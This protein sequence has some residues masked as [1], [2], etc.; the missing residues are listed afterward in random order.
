MVGSALVL[1]VIAVLFLRNQIRPIRQLAEAAE[2]FG[3]GHD[4]PDFRP[5][6]AAE[7]RQAGR[8]FMVMRN[9]IQ[10]QVAT[11][12]E[13]LAGISHDLRTPLTRMKLQL[14]MMPEGEAAEALAYD[15]SV[16]EHMI[17][18][19]LDFA[20]GDIGETAEEEDMDQFIGRIAG[21][22]QNHDGEVTFKGASQT[23]MPVRR[24][25][26]ARALHNL[27]DNAL[28]YGGG[29]A[30]IATRRDGAYIVITIADAG[31]GVPEDKMEEI[32]QPFRR[33]E[34]SRNQETGGAGLGLSIARDA[35]QSHGG[36]IELRNRKKGG[37]LVTINL[38]VE[39]QSQP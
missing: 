9:R 11:R 12:T 37:L 36:T 28:R 19:Y 39:Q 1:L 6:G 22:Y 34:V 8:A 33:M 17:Q 18:E 16:M 29:K 4:I 3:L 23:R 26:L 35:I 10:R 5:R 38:P 25:L 20:R 2:K 24:N 30:Q 15:I 7:V 21:R 14:A 27:I 32:F 31:P 13:M